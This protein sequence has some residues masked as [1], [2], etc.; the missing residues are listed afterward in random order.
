[1]PGASITDGGAGGGALTAVLSKPARPAQIL[2][3]QSPC[4]IMMEIRYRLYCSKPT[5][6]GVI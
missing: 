3:V 6:R 5:R 4:C 1:M 2:S